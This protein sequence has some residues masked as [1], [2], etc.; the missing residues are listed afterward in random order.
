M[1]RVLYRETAAEDWRDVEVVEFHPRGGVVIRETGRLFCGV[2]LVNGYDLRV[3]QQ[4][5][6]R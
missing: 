2:A 3:A 5:Q 6:E 4:R 1:Q